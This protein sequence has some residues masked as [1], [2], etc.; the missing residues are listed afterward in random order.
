MIAKMGAPKSHPTP[1]QV[2]GARV[3]EARLRR[4]WSQSELARRLNIDRT[5]LNK[6]ERGV[7]GDVSISQLFTFADV[8]H[9]S[10]TH[11]LTPRAADGEVQL[12]PGRRMGA[13]DARLWI[14]GS[15]PLSGDDPLEWFLDLPRD[16]QR[17]V[18][19][20]SLT[21]GMNDLYRALMSDDITER[22]DAV[23]K[24]LQSKEAQ[25]G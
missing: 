13:A 10:P 4:E 15:L 16:E 5:T 2:F 20:S 1:A 3:R 21:A 14:R 18:L 17:T 22:V 11:L 25:D 7:R 8:L 9:I 19:E 6:I 23:M 12:T 24:A